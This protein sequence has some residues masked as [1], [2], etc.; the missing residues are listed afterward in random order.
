[1]RILLIIKHQVMVEHIKMVFIMLFNW[2]TLVY[3]N[4]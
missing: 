3:H 2:K 4:H 1:M